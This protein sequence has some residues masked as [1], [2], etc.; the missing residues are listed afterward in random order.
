MKDT[1]SLDIAKKLKEAGWPQSQGGSADV[2]YVWTHQPEAPKAVHLSGSDGIHDYDYEPEWWFNAPTIAE[3]L[4]ALPDEAED[5]EGSEARL[6]V[7]KTGKQYIATYGDNEFALE[8]EL[9]PNPAD[10]LAL[11]WLALKE[12]KII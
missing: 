1:C 8:A 3:L 4:E 11:L 6:T 9:N 2:C 5:E 10:A 7:T 12:K